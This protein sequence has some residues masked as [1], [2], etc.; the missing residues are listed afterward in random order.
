MN[1]VVKLPSGKELEITPT[2]FR[3]SNALF[4]VFL[5]K[6]NQVEIKGQADLGNLVRQVFVVGLSEDKSEAA[7]WDCMK[8]ALYDKLK[9]DKDTFEP[10]Q[11][12]EDYMSVCWE[13]A[14]YNLAPFLKDLSA[15]LE[16]VLLR[17]SG[18]Q[19]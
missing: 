19:S 11:A 3:I 7:L 5:E 2:P 6:S 9:I 1:Q 13:V 17:I 8:Y 16:R 12:R 18:V 14:H 10:I 4:K 15:L